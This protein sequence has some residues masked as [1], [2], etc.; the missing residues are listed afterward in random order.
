MADFAKLFFNLDAK[1]KNY[2]VDGNIIPIVKDVDNDGVVES[3]DGDF[4]IIIFGMRRGGGNYYALNV[5]DKYN[6][7][8]L[9]QFSD[10]GIGQSWQRQDASYKRYSRRGRGGGPYKRKQPHFCNN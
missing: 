3:G 6:P 8:L 1:Y 4:V 2:G 9:W 10:P 7:Q 5:T